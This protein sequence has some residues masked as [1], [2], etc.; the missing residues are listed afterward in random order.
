MPESLT[1]KGRRGDGID[2]PKGLEGYKFLIEKFYLKNLLAY[3][4]MSFRI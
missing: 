4:I 3:A 1:G 2:S